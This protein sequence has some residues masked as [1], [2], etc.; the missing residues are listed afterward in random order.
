[1][2]QIKLG[3]IYYY[4]FAPV[5]YDTLIL[6]AELQRTELLYVPIITTTTIGVCLIRKS[7]ITCSAF[8]SPFWKPN[9]TWA[10][11]IKTLPFGCEPPLSPARFYHLI[12]F[13]CVSRVAIL[14][15]VLSLLYRNIKSG[16]RV[17]VHSLNLR[18]KRDRKTESRHS[19]RL[20]A[21][22]AILRTKF[23]TYF[24]NNHFVLFYSA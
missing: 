9:E 20:P 3:K 22:T 12:N 18:T 5:K 16:R 24:C 11:I 10:N 7:Q 6:K 14:V 17:A 2:Q 21:Q 4:Y 13:N 19:D 15:V 1:M 8:I 23:V